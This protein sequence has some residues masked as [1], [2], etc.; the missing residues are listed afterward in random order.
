MLIRTLV[1]V[2]LIIFVG[3][4]GFVLV[5]SF[6]SSFQSCMEQQTGREGLA[7][8]GPFILTINNYGR[9]PTMLIEYAVEFCELAA[10]HALNIWPAI[11]G[12]HDPL[13]SI[14]R[15]RTGGTLPLFR[16]PISSFTNRWCMEDF[17]ISRHVPGVAGV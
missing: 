3:L 5:E 4:P 10:N 14:H 1:A 8:N 6:S 16:M 11:T 17:G 7:P 12:E 2:L 13:A 9:T 15:L